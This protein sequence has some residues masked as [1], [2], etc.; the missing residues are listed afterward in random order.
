[1]D[2]DPNFTETFRQE[3]HENLNDIEEALLD[4]EKSPDDSACVHRLFRAMH[5][6]KGSGAMFGFNNISD[7]AHHAEAVLEQ[8]RQGIVPVTGTLVDLIFMAKDQ[9]K[10]MLDVDEAGC[11]V[12]LD[13]ACKTIVG[14]LDALLKQPE[15]EAVD[16]SMEMA[17][18]AETTSGAQKETIYRI[19]FRPDPMMMNSGL[20]PMLL[21][22][23]LREIGRCDVMTNTEAVPVLETLEPEKLFL[24]WDLLLSTSADIKTIK[25]VFIFVEDACDIQIRSLFV[26]SNIDDGH[27]PR[28]GEIL[29]DR[30]DVN[31]ESIE[32]VL[33]GQKRI[34]ERLVETGNVSGNIVESALMEQKALERRKAETE[35]DTVRVSS[36]KLDCLMNLVGEIV[37]A[38]AHMS[39]LSEDQGTTPFHAP[40]KHMERMTAD[41]RAIALD[42]RMLPVGTLFRRF[43]RLVRDLSSGLGKDVELELEGV[44]TELDKTILERLHDPLVHLIRNGIDHGIGT[45]EE[46]KRMGKSRKGSIRLT[47]AHWGGRIYITVA[48]DGTG[49]DMASVREKALEKGL[50]AEGDELSELETQNLIFSPGFSTARNI[51]CVS[52]RG[53]GLDVVKQEISALGG[54]IGIKSIQDEGTTFYLSLPLT[55][56]LVEGFHVKVNEK[57]FIIPVS[58]VETCGKVTAPPEKGSGIQNVI[59]FRKELMPFVRLRHFFGIPG[60]RRPVEH[61]VAVQAGHHRIAIVVDEVLGNVQTVIKPLDPIYRLA[62]GISGA[63]VMGSGAIALIVDIQELLRCVKEERPKAKNKDLRQTAD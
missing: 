47:A 34:G 3:A 62:E 26:D 53:V 49:L 11:K 15:P 55:L 2:Q 56:A 10:A 12:D 51:T 59:R 14:K 43:R 1:M 20:D 60:D 38:Q 46:R 48:D 29:V 42:M 37:V 7:F 61:L 32:A 8:V 21:L 63:T 54:T 28:L 58:Q 39:Q 50:I 52:G 35:A 36:E 4:L 13:S 6:I 45:P 9:M 18:Q 41:L 27:C 44:Q 17:K 33:Q 57:D 24:S 19:R 31:A 25:D 22:N 30:G 23:E 40:V 16:P 5:S